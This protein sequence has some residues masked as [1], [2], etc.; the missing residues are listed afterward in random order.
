L[1]DPRAARR[2]RLAARTLL[3]WRTPRS[4]A[5][6]RR[7]LR[8]LVA[9][10]PLAAGANLLINEPLLALDDSGTLLW[11]LSETLDD[12]L[13]RDQVF[14][15]REDVYA[16]ASVV[17]DETFEASIADDATTSLWRLG[18][19]GAQVADAIRLA[20][21]SDRPALNVL[22]CEGLLARKGVFA[23]P[24]ARQIVEQLMRQCGAPAGVI[25]KLGRAVKV[26]YAVRLLATASIPAVSAVALMIARHADPSLSAM[27][28]LE[29]V[30]GAS[31]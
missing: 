12:P 14:R 5:D 10:H 17:T 8:D 20:F 4:N 3:E 11:Y 26:R 15:G 19:T 7:V 25:E 27:A 18:P 30:F 23:P 22:G 28:V 9:V 1:T 16:L 2:L 13:H 6:Y 31:T 24:R 21:L 29:R